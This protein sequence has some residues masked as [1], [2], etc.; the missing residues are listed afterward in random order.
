M[1]LGL[2]AIAPACSSRRLSAFQAT[3]A[4]K[5]PTHQLLSS[6]SAQ[7]LFT[8]QKEVQ[9]HNRVRLVRLPTT[10]AEHPAYHARLASS[11]CL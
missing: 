6:L 1:M 5:E 8:A 10:L 9:L 4:Q 11:A 3:T 7:Q 2:H